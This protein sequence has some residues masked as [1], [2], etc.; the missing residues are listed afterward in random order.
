MSPP[1]PADI[2]PVPGAMLVEP[3]PRQSG[4]FEGVEEQAYHERKFEELRRYTLRTLLT[5]PPLIVFLWAWD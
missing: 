1:P 2:P 4:R 3:F 5:L